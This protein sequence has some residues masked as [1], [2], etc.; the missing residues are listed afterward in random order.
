MV[1]SSHFILIAKSQINL[2][3]EKDTDNA[4]LYMKYRESIYSSMCAA[5]IKS[6][7]GPYLNIRNKQIWFC[8]FSTDTNHINRL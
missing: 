6:I 3:F 2:W 7:S 5:M 4:A 1:L 8:L